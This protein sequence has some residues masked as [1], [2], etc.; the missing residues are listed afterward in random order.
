MRESPSEIK[1]PYET[2]V[3]DNGYSL[4]ADLIDDAQFCSEI[5][6]QGLGNLPVLIPGRKESPVEHLRDNLAKKEPPAFGLLHCRSCVL[7]DGQ[8]RELF[9]ERQYRTWNPGSFAG[10]A[11]RTCNIARNMHNPGNS[12]ERHFLPKALAKE[13]PM[14]FRHIYY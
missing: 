14:G 13:L 1:R 10:I 11:A 12:A 6:S 4:P 8:R 2:L 5:E 3:E 7:E 9:D